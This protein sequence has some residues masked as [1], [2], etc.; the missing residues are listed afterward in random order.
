MVRSI[1]RGS[2]GVQLLRRRGQWS[3]GR[4]A[5]KHGQLAPL[6]CSLYVSRWLELGA[7]MEDPSS[8]A[9]FTHISARPDIAPAA[10]AW[11]CWSYR[12]NHR[13]ADDCNE[14]AL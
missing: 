5:K 7:L 1:A 13:A 12:L 8:S 6:H 9:A 14:N 11:P 4:A 2:L 10:S 3:D